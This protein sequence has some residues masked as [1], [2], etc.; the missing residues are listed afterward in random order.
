[1]PAHQSIAAENSLPV[2]ALLAASGGF[3]DAFT[4]VGHG[5]VFANTMTANVVL[6][7]VYA[8][9]GNWMQSWRHL[10]P[11]LAFL[12]GV[13]AAQSI[14]LPRMSKWFANPAVVALG[15][16]IAFLFAGG[17]LPDSFPSVPLVLGISFL[18]ALQ[19]SSFRLLEKWPY[20][21]TMTTG[22]LRSLAELSFQALSQPGDAE[23]PR[24]AK[25][26]GTICLAFLAGAVLG[27]ICTPRLNNKSLWAAGVLLLFAWLPV[28][29]A[30]R[31]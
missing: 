3:L 15:A 17:W 25:L 26:I 1:M 6:L 13:A 9:T 21:S 12:L 30:S 20:N 23:A 4:Y 14:R 29:R 31:N 2:A 24:R 5:H 27:G 11:I 28:F 8:A 16:E 19:S 7:G 10:P 22:N 18:A